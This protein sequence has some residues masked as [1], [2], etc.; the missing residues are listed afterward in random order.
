MDGKKPIPKFDD[1]ANSVTGLSGPPDKSS[2]TFFQELPRL[3]AQ[4]LSNLYEQEPLAARIIDRLV[5]D[6]TREGFDVQDV[7][8]AYNWGSI[9]S[10]L[11]D[12]EALQAL[13]DSWRWSR[14]Y[15]GALTVMAVND[16]LPFDQPMDMSQVRGISGIQ[17]LESP[18]V[19][20]DQFNPGLGSRAFTRPS[21]Y[22]VNLP[23]GSGRSKKI[24]HSRV[25]RWDGMRVS[26]SRNL[27]YGGWGPSVL[28]RIVVE[29]RQLGEVMGYA[30]GILHD[31]SMM[32]MKFEGFR[33][34]MCGAEQDR[35]DLSRMMETIRMTMDNLHLLVLDKE[36]EFSE[37]S[38]SVSG[39]ELMI[40]KF[41]DALVRSTDL[42]RTILLGEQP[43]GLNASAD[44]EIRSW[45][46]YV[47]SQQRMILT[48]PISQLLTVMLAIRKN[49]GEMVPEEFNVIYNP[50][51]QPT[52]QEQADTL[53]KYSQASQI[54]INSQI[55]TP[56][57]L[58]AMIISQGLLP[59]DTETPQEDNFA[60]VP[61]EITI[62]AMAST[63]P[64]PPD[65]VSVQEAAKAVGVPT[66]T[67][68]RQIELGNIPYWGYGKRVQV[69]MSQVMEAGKQDALHQDA[70]HMDYSLPS[71]GI[72]VRVP[73]HLAR[74]FPYKP[75]EPSP[76]H[77]TVLNLGCITEHE[78]EEVREVLARH[79]LQ[80]PVRA[81][82][83]GVDYFEGE[84]GRIAYVRV[85]LD[86]DLSPWRE[87]ILHELREAGVLVETDIHP[88]WIPHVTLAY[89]R[90][91]EEYTGPTPEGDFVFRDLEV[92]HGDLR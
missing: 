65:M 69:S 27:G 24:H 87:M 17:V 78:Y 6:G 11:E 50:L 66:R 82:F 8:L 30:R 90:L 60:T 70:E 56:Q 3:Q 72:F 10:E 81:R 44:S 86:Q 51:W 92:W 5:D 35:A 63:E 79:P 42:P 26:P 80:D 32:H 58:A 52:A 91:N 22:I 76:P 73:D 14:L 39:L 43:S 40:D 31:I 71:A 68:T 61:Q 19:T 49:R 2:Y 88:M 33:T 89:L 29:L 74:L 21:H 13:A 18:Y 1:Y 45:Y 46:D 23:F 54:L 16:G 67:L 28:Q 41:V 83:E 59:E 34:Q 15:G 77:I 36:D 25:L 20:P 47:H 4:Q 53:L 62:P 7:D 48:P 84:V 38:R 9:K 55:A 12:L 85:S 75:E 64:V 37:V 57:Q